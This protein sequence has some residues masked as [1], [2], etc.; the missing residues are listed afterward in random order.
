MKVFFGIA[1]IVLLLLGV[2]ISLPFLVDLNKYQDRYRPLIEDALNR[3]VVLQDIRLTVW[4]RIG[5]RV[6]G[7]TVQDDP[8][9]RAGPF[10]SLSSLDVGVKLWPLLSGRVEVEEIT[11]RDPLI[12]V[13]KN[14]AGVLNVSTLGAQAPAAPKP[15]TPPGEPAGGPLRAL[16]L[17]AVDKISIDG[18][19]LIYRDEAKPVPV[20][21]TVHDLEFLLTSVH[22]GDT[23]QLHA[24]AALQP[25]NLPVKIDGTFGPLTETLD[26]KHFDVAL[27]L[28]R[29]PISVK[30][31]AAG[32]D[33]D[34][35]VSSS[36]IDT[37][38]IPVALPL[39]K[40]VQIKNLHLTAHADYGRAT[41]GS[42]LDTTEVKDL[43]LAL[44]M[45]QSVVNIKG[46]AARGVAHITAASSN[47]NSGDLPLALPLAKPVDI[48]NFHMSARA[49]YP[50]KEGARPL[51]L[52]DVTDLGFIAVLGNS[53]ADV[54]GTLA[55]GTAKASLVSKGINTADLPIVLPLKNPVQITGLH[56]TA[57]MRGQDVRLNNLVFEIFNGSVKGQA[58]A[59]LGSGAPPFHAA[60]TAE[61]L[62]LRPLANAAG[63]TA[64]SVSG[65][66][67]TTF[68]IGGR[69]TTRADLTKT[70]EGAGT[71][72]VKD[73]KLEGLNLMQEVTS[74]LKV[75]GLSAE[76][77][78]ATVFSTISSDLTVNQ[79]L[80]TVQRLLMD[81]HDF[82][83]TGKGTVGFDQTV[84]LR[85]NM[86][87]SQSLSQ[88]IA[89]ASPIA[90]VA[91][92]GGRLSLPLLV[93]GTVQA[94]SYS[95]DTKMFAEKAQEQA[96]QKVRETVNDLLQGNRTPEDLRK[97]G[98]SL[99]KDLLGR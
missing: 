91:L 80:I 11:L 10:A 78:K 5:A 43:G 93:T 77:V 4:P 29:I 48:K 42:L 74:L 62:Q 40:P 2:A 49:P 70:L 37:A 51:E 3:K 58:S 81:S 79:G 90:K 95:L 85:L 52:A 87:L 72:A 23:A 65:T 15:T 92:S 1:I 25:Y 94:P 53:T 82:Q 28:G 34:I 7:F 83:A 30:G 63:L 88:R 76:G 9:F 38:E 36:L 75:A 45:G 46:T 20:E 26:L 97:Q 39:T 32:G 13:F 44:T 69:G 35:T 33:L 47:I 57:E 19:K 17:L 68:R 71:V 66:A 54:Q 73:G 22:L 99:L 27:G 89:A 56:A 14:K 8:S 16:A 31:G 12:V 50:P 41:T 55:A 59:G 86:N 98:K 96:K 18:G 64:A 84:F 60:L 6:A 67:A 61:G 21:Y 24:A